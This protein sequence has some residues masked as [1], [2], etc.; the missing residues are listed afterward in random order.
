MQISLSQKETAQGQSFVHPEKATGRVGVFTFA[1]LFP[2][3]KESRCQETSHQLA[4]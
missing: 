4:A 3:M 2:N 1:F